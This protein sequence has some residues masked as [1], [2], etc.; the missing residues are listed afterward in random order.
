MVPESLRTGFDI[1]SQETS[2]DMKQVQGLMMLF[3]EDATR[4]ACRCAIA[5]GSNEIDALTMRRALQYEAMNF[6]DR[7]DLEPRFMEV[8]QNIDDS[9]T[10]EA[11]EDYE[12]TD[13]E[14]ESS[15]ENDNTTMDCEPTEDD[16]ILRDKVRLAERNWASWEPTDPVQCLIKNSVDSVNV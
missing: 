6:F 2:F 5:D 12:S 14:D 1:T 3:I 16:L 11:D 4:T 9:E 13:C 15:S 10:S 7:D 8:M